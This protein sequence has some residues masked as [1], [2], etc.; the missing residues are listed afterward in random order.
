VLDGLKSMLRNRDFLVLLVLFFIGLGLFNAVTTWIEDIVRLRQF[1]P[2]EA[3]LAGGMMVV[4]GIVG[5]LVIPTLSDRTRRR[6]PFM[7]LA[8]AGAIR[9]C[10]ATFAT[11]YG[12]F[13]PRASSSARFSFRPARSGSSTEPRSLTRRPRERRTGSCSSWGR[14]R[15]SPSSSEWTRSSPHRGR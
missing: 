2:A 1:T 4:G 8:L 12:L 13:S 3:G 14:F 9:A 11:S 10:S 15:A 7:L 6:V 5:A